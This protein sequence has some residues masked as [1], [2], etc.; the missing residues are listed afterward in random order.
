MVKME[1]EQW[2]DMIANEFQMLSKSETKTGNVPLLR[3]R[4]DKVEI[5]LK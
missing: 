1:I 5:I 3:F 2:S 4:N